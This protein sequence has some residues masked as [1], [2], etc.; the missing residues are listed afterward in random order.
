[1]QELALKRMRQITPPEYHE[2]LTPKYPLGCK[3]V[4][5]DPGRSFV[6]LISCEDLMLHA[7]QAT[8][9]LSRSPM[10]TL[11]RKVSVG[12]RKRV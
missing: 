1:V 5:L 12:S 7:F 6:R 9:R 4:I 2:A 10:S 3:R 8:M 11:S